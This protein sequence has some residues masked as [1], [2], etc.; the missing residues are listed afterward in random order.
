MSETK[1]VKLSLFQVACSLPR[2]IPEDITREIYDWYNSYR[3]QYRSVMEELKVKVEPFNNQ[4]KYERIS[5]HYK[6]IRTEH[7]GYFIEPRSFV[8]DNVSLHTFGPLLRWSYRGHC[9][10][11]DYLDGLQSTRHSVHRRMQ[12]YYQTARSAGV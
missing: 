5:P 8:H 12:E 10:I 3:A 7:G 4:R 6:L 11:D 2:H 9:S 1:E